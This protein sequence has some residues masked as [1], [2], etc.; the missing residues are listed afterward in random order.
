MKGS[1]R[2][3]GK[4][5]WQ[6]RICVGR[7]AEG[8]YKYKSE[9]VHS[10][11]KKD[12]E[13]RLV[14]LLRQYNLGQLSQPSSMTVGEY[15]DYWLRECSIDW[16]PETKEL[17]GM[18][19]RLHIKPALGHIRLDKLTPLHIQQWINEELRSGKF[20]P[21]TVYG[22]FRV[23][24]AAL[25]QAAEYNLIPSPPPALRGVKPPRKKKSG[26]KTLTQEQVRK[27]LQT[28]REHD[29]YALYLMAITC[30]MR[31]GEILG[32]RW[33][34]IDLAHG[35]IHIQQQL[36]AKKGVKKARFEPPKTEQ[37]DRYLPMP[38]I[39]IDALRAHRIAQDIEREAY[40][41]S[42][43]NLDLVFTVEGGGP[44][45]PRNLHRQY[46]KLLRKAGL[47][48]IR[49]HDLRHSC[50]SHLAA[51]HVPARE[52]SDFAGHA[53][54]EFTIRT[55]EHVLDEMSWEPARVMDKMIS[56]MLEKD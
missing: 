48:D 34:D 24:R 49:F 25:Y 6:I 8:R 4:D 44:I 22:H 36:K 14:E 37:G 52:I 39:L 40:G 30:A 5:T 42:Y 19:V 21:D 9:T 26:G 29:R 55:Y 50:L 17:N 12:A 53:D 1:I 10:P 51:Q 35:V 32:L 28:I 20:A 7:D 31:E 23:L 2:S 16:T 11:N 15:L 43:K 38:Q 56:E 27:F 46:K 13:A 3:R 33:Q 18:I 45:S 41:K 47:P 54:V